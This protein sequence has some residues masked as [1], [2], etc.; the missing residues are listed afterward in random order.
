MNTSLFV[1]L[2]ELIFDFPFV[3]AVALHEFLKVPLDK[4]INP[5]HIGN[6]EN[7]LGSILKINYAIFVVNKSTEIIRMSDIKSHFQI[8]L[9]LSNILSEVGDLCPF[10]FL[11]TFTGNISPSALSPCKL[12]QNKQ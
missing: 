10:C 2:S 1:C 7:R 6:I 4:Y 12:K 8:K 5:V 3:N 9:M 11:G